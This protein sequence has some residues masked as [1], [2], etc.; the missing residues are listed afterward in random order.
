MAELYKF[1]EVNKLLNQEIDA[2][3]SMLQANNALHS[4]ITSL[5]A[6]ALAT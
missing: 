4:N 3:D 6:R 2:L 1:V 5:D